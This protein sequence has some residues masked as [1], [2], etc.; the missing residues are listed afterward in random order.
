[1]EEKNRLDQIRP[2]SFI[3]NDDNEE[4][5]LKSKDMNGLILD[6]YKRHTVANLLIHK[7]LSEDL[8]P[9]N[10]NNIRPLHD[11]F[12]RENKKT[13]KKI[14]KNFVNTN[15]KDVTLSV[16]L[17]FMDI[18]RTSFMYTEEVPYESH[19][20]FDAPF[21]MMRNEW[22]HLKFDIIYDDTILSENNEAIEFLVN[23]AGIAL[24]KQY[25]DRA[26]SDIVTKYFEKIFYKMISFYMGKPEMLQLFFETY[27][28]GNFYA[29]SSHGM[30]K[31]YNYLS[32]IIR[33]AAEA[34]L[35]KLYMALEEIYIVNLGLCVGIYC[36]EFKEFDVEKYLGRNSYIAGFLDEINEEAENMDLAE[37]EDED[38]EVEFVEGEVDKE[39]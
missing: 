17:E 37:D 13:N 31:A 23:K 8:K 1:M 2:V 3:A 19:Y 22:K 27:I 25:V 12:N 20:E 38:L 34:P 9:L 21:D 10:F 4:D 28:G 14:I 35:N 29:F 24:T 11:T 5:I 33:E 26:Y 18:F 36:D 6:P 32:T 7:M 16:A 39:E 30:N 15:I